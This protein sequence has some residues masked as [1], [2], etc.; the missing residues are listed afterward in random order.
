MLCI[1]TSIPNSTGRCSGGGPKVE[2]ITLVVPALLH[3]SAVALMSTMR[4]AGFV[5]DSNTHSFA[6]RSAI[7]ETMRS[8]STGRRRTPNRESKSRSSL[9][10]PPYSAVAAMTSSP[11]ETSPS[12]ASARTAR[13]TLSGG[14]SMALE[15][16][17]IDREPPAERSATT[18]PRTCRN[19][20]SNVD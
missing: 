20:P 8:G 13:I 15:R 14:T 5:G 11:A 9:Y 17:E 2:S 7:S 18:R 16:L 19:E 1:T 10:V 4:S 3:A 6:G 12:R